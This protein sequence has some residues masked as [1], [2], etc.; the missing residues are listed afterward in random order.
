MHRRDFLIGSLSGVVVGAG[1]EAL[2]GYRLDQQIR[3]ARQL[4]Q[5]LDHLGDATA[6][7]PGE[8]GVV[9]VT[10]YGKISFAQQGEDLIVSN[11]LH[12][13]LRIE[14]PTYIDIGAHDPIVGS[15]TFLLYLQEA[16][17]VLVE[18]NPH[19]ADKLRRARPE[20]VTL[21]IGIGI[22][23]QTEADFY[24][25]KG[26]GQNNTFDSDQVDRYVADGGPEVVEDVIKMP[27]VNVNKVLTEQFEG[28]AV[29]FLSIYVEGLDLAILETLDLDAHRPKV[30]CAET[31]IWGTKNTEASIS[32]F[33]LQQDYVI[34]GGT[35]VNTVF[36]D[37]RLL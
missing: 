11:I 30:I 26:G 2:V 1:V 16:R 14:K 27:L 24:I 7:P 13:Y 12:Q 19:F 32:D 29:D 10:E 31:M 3:E 25:I 28:G 33:L 18:P 21:N 22:T 5:Q 6:A 20:D 8:D 15:N 4:T 36:V 35:F 37:S 34:R 23:D 9:D 17:G